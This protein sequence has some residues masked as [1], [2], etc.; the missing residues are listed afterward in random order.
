[1]IQTLEVELS[2][3]I[4]VNRQALTARSPPGSRPTRGSLTEFFT[5]VR[6]FGHVI[7]GGLF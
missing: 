4:I 5:A 3:W 6:V 2:S 1:M 7:H